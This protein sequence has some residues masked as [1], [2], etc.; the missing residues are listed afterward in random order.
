MDSLL[1]IVQMPGGVPVGTLAIGEAGANNAGAARRAD[2]GPRRTR[3]LPSGSRP[4]VPSRRR[5]CRG[6]EGRCLRA[7]PPSRCL[8]ARPSASSA[9]ASS[10]A[11]WRMAAARLGLETHPRPRGERPGL[12]RG[13]AH[14]SGRLRRSGGAL[15]RFAA[16]VD[17]VTYEFENVAVATA[18]PSCGTGAGAARAPGR[19]RWRRTGWSRRSSSPRL[20]I[21]VAPFQGVD[22]QTSR[23]RAR[24]CRRARDPEDAPP[25]LRRQGPGGRGAGRRSGG[26]L[27]ADRRQA[28]HP[29]EARRLRARALRA[30]GARRGRR[31]S[32]S[33]IARAT[34]TRTA[35]CA[36]RW[37]PR[38]CPPTTS[39]APATSPAASPRRSTTSACW[40]WRCSTSAPTRRGRAPDGQRDRAARAQLRPLDH[41]GLRDQPVRE[42]HARGGRLAARLDRAPFRC[43]DGQPDRQG[44]A[45]LAA[46]AA[47]P[48]ACL[49]LYGKR[50]AR[51]GR[52][53]GHVTRLSARS[54]PQRRG[55]P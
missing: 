1:S 51:A 20:G 43:R 17:V 23:D 5:P 28:R 44:G 6:P 9:A 12:R 21:P 27:A 55:K 30:G 16:A 34:R 15:A 10:D 13:D 47:E 45:R 52:K 48:G 24:S 37:C 32:P 38:A 29:R 35:S 50:D 19:W 49:H 31:G 25:R 7:H 14:Q 39:P 40:R 54:E 18:P 26:G 4:Y 8:L 46:L 41:R 11:C 3:T 36:A 33:T 53:M 22:G 42:P 2:P